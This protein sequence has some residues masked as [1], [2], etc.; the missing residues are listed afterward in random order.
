MLGASMEPEAGEQVMTYGTVTNFD[1]HATVR[2]DR[3]INASIGKVWS[4]LTTDAE[5]ATWL[6]PTS[7]PDSVGGQVRI[8]F[9]PDQEVA[10]EVLT[11]EPNA[12]LE[13]TWTFTGEPDSVLRFELAGVGESTQLILEHRLLPADQAVGYGA[14]W[15]AYLDR[16]A[17]QVSDGVPPDWET[18][19]DEVLGAYVGA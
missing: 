16:L 7:M 13:F 5:L 10:G 2:F 3:K 9:G 19:F 18:R 12:A 6:A 15:H 1:D 8:D 17:A 11:I 4:A 14:G